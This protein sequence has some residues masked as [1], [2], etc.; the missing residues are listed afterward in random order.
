MPQM[1]TTAMNVTAVRASKPK[2]VHRAIQLLLLAEMSFSECYRN[3]VTAHVIQYLPDYPIQ[4]SESRSLIP[5]LSTMKVILPEFLGLF[6][7]G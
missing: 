3:K 5:M 2:D 6:I 1:L 7:H 4:F